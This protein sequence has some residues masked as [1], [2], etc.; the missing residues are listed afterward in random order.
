[1]T[2]GFRGTGPARRVI[3]LCCLGAVA[4]VLLPYLVL[5][6]SFEDAT[7]EFFQGQTSRVAAAGLGVL[8]LAADMI[9]PIPSSVVGT[10][11]GAALGW[12]TGMLAT[13]AG[14]TIGCVLGFAL[15]RSGGARFVRSRASL[16]ERRLS[17]LLPRYGVTILVVCRAVPIL[18]EA[19]VMA[20]G[21]LGLPL[22]RCLAATT[23]ANLAVAAVYAAIGAAIWDLS[24]ATAFV[25]ALLLPGLLLALTVAAGRLWTQ[26]AHR[27]AGGAGG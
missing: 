1:M 12:W 25:A 8:L 10:G 26:H 18:A 20:A 23:L 15:G 6:P 24:P 17:E 2:H 22:W 16:H 19:S 9:L 11:L 3:A 4:V 14:L 27:P 21:A 5:G 13:A 7:A